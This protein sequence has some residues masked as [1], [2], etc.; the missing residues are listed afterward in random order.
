MKK[1]PVRIVISISVCL[2]LLLTLVL[3]TGCASKKPEKTV[4]KLID[5]L[6]DMDIDGIFDCF[7]PREARKMRAVYNASAGLL[8]MLTGI[9]IDFKDLLMILPMF[10]GLQLTADSPAFHW[11]K[12]SMRY[13][14]IAVQDDRARIAGQLR[15]EE[16]SQ[17][18][19]QDVIFILK[20][21]DGEWYIASTP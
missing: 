16:G 11:P 1:S 9:D 12:F 4:E 18:S 7:E 17:V 10:D 3:T 6:N 5:A 19:S 2:C 21:I 14:N 8:G 15:I 20:K 13:D